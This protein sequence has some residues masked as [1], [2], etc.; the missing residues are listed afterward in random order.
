VRR[1]SSQAQFEALVGGG[2]E[3]DD[4]DGAGACDATLG[5]A[6]YERFARRHAGAAAARAVFARTKPLRAAAAARAAGG[7]AAA[8]AAAVPPAPAG[9]SEAAV[10][11]VRGVCLRPS[12]PACARY[13]C[14]GNELTGLNL[15]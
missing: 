3:S 14:L 11:K 12:A 7:A 4:G 5:W 2:A 9:A 8:A 10:A 15:K 13:I 1:R 6:L